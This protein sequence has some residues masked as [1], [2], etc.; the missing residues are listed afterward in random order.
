VDG[1]RRVVSI[2]D[3]LPACG[4]PSLLEEAGALLEDVEQHYVQILRSL[5]E[6]MLRL[7]ASEAPQ[8][9]KGSFAEHHAPIYLPFFPYLLMALHRRTGSAEFVRCLSQ[10]AAT[11]AQLPAWQRNAGYD[12]VLPLGYDRPWERRNADTGSARDSSLSLTEPDPYSLETYDPR[13]ANVLL[14]ATHDVF[15]GDR[16]S[17][18]LPNYGG[19][20]YRNLRNI[21]VPLPFTLNCLSWRQALADRAGP[22]ARTRQFRVSFVGFL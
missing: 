15:F 1:V 13:F 18:F 2:A 17:I 3:N 20:A 21:V 8:S 7:A 16:Q 22:A 4:G 14:L 9:S 19:A 12:F 6:A 5:H 10:T 11:L